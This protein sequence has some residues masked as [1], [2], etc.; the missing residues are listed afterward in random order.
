MPPESRPGPAASGATSILWTALLGIALVRLVTAR[1]PAGVAEAEPDP[2]DHLGQ[3][4]KSYSGR[5]A[6]WVADTEGDRGRKAETPM[7]IPAKGW[8]DVLTRVYLE[9]QKDRVL[10][11]AAG[12]TFYTL[13]AIFPAVAALVS[14]YGLFTD[15]STIND[16]LSLLQGVLPSGALEIIGDQVK[17]ITAKGSTT[18]GITFFTSLAISLWSA[19]ASMKAMFDALNIVYEEREKRSFIQLNL[20]SLAFTFGALVFVVVALGGIVVLPVALNFLGNFGI[21]IS[22]TAWYVA[23]LRWPALL[24]V[25]LFGLALL[26]RF[27]PSRDLPRWRWVTP[28]SLTAGVVWLAASIGF[29]WYVAHFGSYNETYG[30]LGAAIGF[31]TWIWISSTIVLLGGEINAELE[32]QTARDTTVGPEE[33]MGTRRA[34]MA[35]TVGAPA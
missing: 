19:N 34:R 15:P 20:R 35:D 23:L 32:H 12:V 21:S 33:P 29:S 3:G 5:P 18:L 24:A 25:L 6:Q 26:Y 11:V 1:R 30:S 27:G 13:L 28:G 14:L 8:K 31:M 10:S 9:F 7:D 2:T 17:R 4:A 16:H 22:P